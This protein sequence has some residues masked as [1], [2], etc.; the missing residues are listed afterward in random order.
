[1]WN[2]TRDILLERQREERSRL[3]CNPRHQQAVAEMPFHTCARCSRWSKSVLTQTCGC[4]VL[5]YCST[6]CQAT[7]FND[8]H[9]LVCHEWTLNSN[10]FFQKNRVNSRYGFRL[11]SHICDAVLGIRVHVRLI[12][13]YAEPVVYARSVLRDRPVRFSFTQSDSTV[14]CQTRQDVVHIEAPR[15]RSVALQMSSNAL[16][17]TDYSDEDV[18]SLL[19]ATTTRTAIAEDTQHADTMTL[20]KSSSLHAANVDDDDDEDEWGTSS[21]DDDDNEKRHHSPPS[22][23]ALYTLAELQEMEDKQACS[24]LTEHVFCSIQSLGAYLLFHPDVCRVWNRKKKYWCVDPDSLIFTGHRYH[25]EQVCSDPIRRLVTI[26][27]P[28]FSSASPDVVPS[29]TP[30]TDTS[31]TTPSPPQSPCSRRSITRQ[32]ACTPRL[33]ASCSSSPTFMAHVA[34]HSAWC[35][36]TSLLRGLQRFSHLQS[37]GVPSRPWDMLDGMH[38]ILTSFHGRRSQAVHT[39]STHTWVILDCCRLPTDDRKNK[40][41]TGAPPLAPSRPLTPLPFE[42]CVAL[43]MPESDTIWFLRTDALPALVYELAAILSSFID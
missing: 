43:S 16:D 17:A 20:F 4:G 31:N 14:C 2:R 12:V 25:A 7:F 6:Y 10:D 23:P 42:P 15:A 13:E 35:K 19:S 3:E 40:S 28:S 30:T 39:R 24:R 21:D 34:R 1:M 27:G 22:A 29:N 9:R 37:V 5:W 38:G 33:P 8:S 26:G 32:R 36:W 41:E 18:K 11:A